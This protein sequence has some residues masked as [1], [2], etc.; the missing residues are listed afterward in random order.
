M[1]I[2]NQYRKKNTILCVC[3][4]LSSVTSYGDAENVRG[5]AAAHKIRKAG[6]WIRTNAELA[7]PPHPELA[8]QESPKGSR[9]PVLLSA[10][11]SDQPMASEPGR[12]FNLKSNI[13]KNIK[14]PLLIAVPLNSY[15]FCPIISQKEFE[16]Q[17]SCF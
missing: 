7:T 8:S 17:N 4:Q 14:L 9:E 12:P 3:C 6:L 10:P 15:L 16:R 11:S 13:S 2:A 5:D 1:A